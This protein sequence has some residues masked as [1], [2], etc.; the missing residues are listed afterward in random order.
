[1]FNKRG[2]ISLLQILIL[3]IG[4]FSFS[5]LSSEFVI[6]CKIGD[7]DGDIICAGDYWVSKNSDEGKKILE[8]TGKE[9]TGKDKPPTDTTSTPRPTSMS[10]TQ[11]AI[12]WATSED[13]V[14]PKDYKWNPDTKQFEFMTGESGASGAGYSFS[15]IVEGAWWAASLYIMIKTLGGM[16]FE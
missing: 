16:F 8:E 13:W 9:L 4:I 6:A 15:G 3:L 7:I 1:M 12:A 11:K 10:S 2:A 5:V 14:A